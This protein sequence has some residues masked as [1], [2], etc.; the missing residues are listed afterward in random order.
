MIDS[1]SW[2]IIIILNKS[3]VEVKWNPDYNYV[4]LGIYYYSYNV[5]YMGS[6][7]QNCKGPE[8]FNLFI[9]KTFNTLPRAVAQYRN[10]DSNTEFQK[11]FLFF[12]AHFHI[13]CT[14]H[15]QKITLRLIFF[16]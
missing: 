4:P 13:M 8:L 10:N 1:W 2:T 9:L 15:K 7:M 3:D 6:W 11:Y 16:T 5:L 12:I 14:L